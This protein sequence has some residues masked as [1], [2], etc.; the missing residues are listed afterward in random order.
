MP[1]AVVGCDEPLF[2]LKTQHMNLLEPSKQPNVLQQ[3]QG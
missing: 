1:A 2:L 3:W